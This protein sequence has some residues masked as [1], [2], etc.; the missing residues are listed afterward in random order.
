MCLAL[1]EDHVKPGDT[2]FDFGCGSAILS[3]A[4]ARLGAEHIEAVDVDSIAVEVAKENARRNKVARKIRV[5]KATVEPGQPVPGAP[6][7]VVAANISAFVLKNA[8]QGVWDAT[9]PGGPA[10]L[11]GILQMGA[12]EVQAAY[13]AVGWEHVETRSEGDW[14]AMVVRRPAS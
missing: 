2:V 4:A 9:K 11:S 3:I 13:E 7:D 5:R 1:L 10:I 8:A 14:V 12:D 6:F